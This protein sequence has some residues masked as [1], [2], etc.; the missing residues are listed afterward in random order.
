VSPPLSQPSFLRPRTPQF[1]SR[2]QSEFPQVESI[3]TVNGYFRVL[4]ALGLIE[5]GSGQISLTPAGREFVEIHDVELVCEAL[6]TRIVG[7]KELLEEL[8]R[9]QRTMEQLQEVMGEVGL[10]WETNSQLGWRLHWLE[11]VG[12][13][14]AENGKYGLVSPSPETDEISALPAE[15]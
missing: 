4:V 12:L 5:L 14:A 3:A 9:G 2:L 15:Q 8:Q 6:R 1:I 7:V 11:S 13:V 10:A